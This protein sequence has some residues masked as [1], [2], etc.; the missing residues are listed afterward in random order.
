M[1]GESH[2]TEIARLLAVALRPADPRLLLRGGFSACDIIRALTI[3][4]AQQQVCGRP[5]RA[6]FRY[7][8]TPGPGPSGRPHAPVFS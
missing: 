2:N 5:A 8:V 1:R 3:P 4:G 6:R 7:F